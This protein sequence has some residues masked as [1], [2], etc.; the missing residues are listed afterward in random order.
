MSRQ[1]ESVSS[2]DSS[3]ILMWAF[4][5]PEKECEGKATGNRGEEE[6]D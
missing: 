3:T 1:L 4:T 5:A 6:C 2:A